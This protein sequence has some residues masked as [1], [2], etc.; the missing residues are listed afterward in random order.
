MKKA[1]FVV[2]LGLGAIYAFSQEDYIVNSDGLNV[3]S[4]PGTNYDV[5]QVIH[6]G[7]MVTV[8][9]VEGYWA[10][11]EFEDSFAYV[12]T[13]LIIPAEKT[14][15]E[16]T[17]KKTDGGDGGWM[18]FLVLLGIVLVALGIYNKQKWNERYH[19]LREKAENKNLDPIERQ[20]AIND[21]NNMEA[22]AREARIKASERSQNTF[23]SGPSVILTPGNTIIKHSF[24]NTD[25]LHD[26][27]GN[28]AIV[29][30]VGDI[31][32]VNHN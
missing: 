9:S 24:G 16:T 3:R 12:H 6:R 29:H 14:V 11:I 25:I 13:D 4:G 2:L 31:D 27:H 22:D 5:L 26:S 28:R 18:V 19:E 30:H 15:I 17:D 32:I 20:L 1:I 21:M 7:D 8:V 23:S 10:M